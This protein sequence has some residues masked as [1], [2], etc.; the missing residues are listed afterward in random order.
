MN[1]YDTLFSAPCCFSWTGSVIQF[2]IFLNVAFITHN[3][4]VAVLVSDASILLRGVAIILPVQ[5]L[6]CREDTSL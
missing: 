2:Q 5:R 1:T 4:T 3:R 6:G